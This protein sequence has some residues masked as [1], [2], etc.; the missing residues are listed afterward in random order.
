MQRLAAG[1]PAPT[2]SL[3]DS[4]GATVSLA[5]YAGSKVIVY[6]Y[7]AAL[8]PGCTTQA[9]DFSAASDTLDA[10]GYQVVGI[11]PDPIAKLERFR[12]KERLSITLLSDPDLGV[13]KA[14]GAYGSKMLYGKEVEGVIRSTFLVS[15]DDSG[16]G[17]ID[18]AQYNVRA[19][20]H[21]AKLQKDL[22]LTK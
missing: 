6:F 12:A 10:A 15:V 19:S 11:S 18:L 9:I 7:P 3:P 8:T 4:N 5:D 1:D 16:S 22:G 2:F 14:Y 17:T 13:L 20:G 21:V